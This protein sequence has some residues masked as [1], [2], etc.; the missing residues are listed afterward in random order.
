MLR[1]DDKGIYKSTLLA[2]IPELVHGYSTRQ[3]GDSRNAEA[4]AKIL[5]LLSVDPT[6][7]IQ[8]EQ[9]HGDQVAIIDERSKSTIPQADALVQK[10]KGV[11]SFALA[12]QFAD[13]VPMLLVDPKHKISAVIHAGWKGTLKGIVTKAVATM[14][15][16]G[17]RPEET[18]ASI[19][20]HIGMCHYDVQKER[21]E[22]F[23]A[24]F[25]KDPQVASFFEEKWHIDLGYINYKQLV[26]VGIHKEHIDALP[27]C[28]SC[29]VDQ[30]FSFRKDAPETFGEIMGVIGYAHGN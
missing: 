4:R 29:Q 25:G 8:A 26:D 28:T 27:T 6:R 11:Q 17:A 5:K 10:A 24:A 18:Y 9:V 16:L 3:L 20:P 13:C 21:A 7:L 12:V 2:G 30:F 19:G 23:I 1:K 22:K 15:S 14:V